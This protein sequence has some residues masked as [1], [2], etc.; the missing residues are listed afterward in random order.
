M[1]LATFSDI[2]QSPILVGGVLTVEDAHT[3]LREANVIVALPNTLE[4]CDPEAREALKALI[5]TMLQELAELGHTTDRFQDNL[6]RYADTIGQADTLEGLAGVVREMVAESRAVQP[7]VVNLNRIWIP[8]SNYW[9]PFGP[10]TFGAVANPNRLAGLTGVPVGG[11][12]VRIT[13]YR[14]VD[15]VDEPDKSFTRFVVFHHQVVLYPV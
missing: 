1:A 4:A 7:P 14:P 10:T 15:A 8:A 13:T 2:M 11:L 3:L 9:N 5:H 12:P 6:G